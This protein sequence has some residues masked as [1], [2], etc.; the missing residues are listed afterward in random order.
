M[1]SPTFREPE[2]GTVLGRRNP[3]AKLSVVVLLTVGA[4]FT[5]D[6]RVLVSLLVL[7][8]AVILLT[9]VPLRTLARR[10]WPLLIAVMG[11]ALTNALLVNLHAAVTVSVRL[12]CITLPGVAVLAS[13]DPRDLADSL[14]Q[15]ARVSPRFAYGAMAG[16]RLLPLFAADWQ[17]LQRARRARGIHRGRT[18]LALLGTAR[19]LTFALLVS[20]V[21]RG[22]RLAAAMDARGF[23]GHEQR[24]TAR[25][26]RLDRADVAM[27]ILAALVATAVAVGSAISAF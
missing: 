18:P 27:V 19:A 6:L 14:V 15:Q 16:L 10:T 22:I 8:I 25:P 1:S 13:T 21:R 4:L 5:A 7:E 11:V 17:H 2:Q 3:V 26:Q 20:A 12:V 23:D 9:G 24:S